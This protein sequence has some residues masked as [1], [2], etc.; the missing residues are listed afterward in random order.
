LL[1]QLGK[2]SNVGN[3]YL[4]NLLKYYELLEE[5]TKANG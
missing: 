5:L 4:V 1:T 3:D 2:T